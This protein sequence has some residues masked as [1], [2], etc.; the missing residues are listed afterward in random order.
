MTFTININVSIQPDRKTRKRLKELEKQM[1]EL[2]NNFNKLKDSV[3]SAESRITAH[4]Q[5][6]QEVATDLQAQIDALQAGNADASTVA[7]GLADLKASIDSFDPDAEA[8]P[9]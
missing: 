7:A 8:Q 6:L 4:E 1:P 5:K 9:A 2:L 3:A